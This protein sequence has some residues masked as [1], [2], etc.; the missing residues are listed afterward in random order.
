MAS[1]SAAAVYLP[2]GESGSFN[3]PERESNFGKEFFYLNLETIDCFGRRLG[4]RNSVSVPLPVKKVGGVIFARSRSYSMVALKIIGELNDLV[5]EYERLQIVK[6]LPHCINFRRLV[7]ADREVVKRSLAIETEDA[8]S[9]LL[10][11]INV[12]SLSINQIR[13]IAKQCVEALK[14]LHDKGVVHGDIKPENI[15]A[16]YPSHI[17]FIDF[18]QLAEIGKYSKGKGTVR[19]S[20]VEYLLGMPV[21]YKSDLW[22]LGV[23]LFFTYTSSNIAGFSY[24]ISLYLNE[25]RQGLDYVQNLKDYELIVSAID[26]YRDELEKIGFKGFED[27]II[28]IFVCLQEFQRAFGEIPQE[29][30][31]SIRNP[32]NIEGDQFADTRRRLSLFLF[33]DAEEDDVYK[34]RDLVFPL[35]E[36]LP[37]EDRIREVG[38]KQNA[39]NCESL[40]KFIKRLCSYNTQ[41]AEELLADPFLSNDF[42]FELSFNYKFIE[43]YFKQ[44]FTLLVRDT[45]NFSNFLKVDLNRNVRSIERD[46]FHL[47]KGSKFTVNVLNSA[48]E[49]ISVEEIVEITEGQILEI[50]RN[51]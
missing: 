17:K 5:D 50:G 51:N 41:T 49:Q 13:L 32:P 47:I 26:E 16:R 11:I 33:N 21:S 37:W 43:K 9:D 46:C 31:E 34:L 48:E 1:P 22:S 20:P 23:T 4:P 14:H 10:E 30:I 7:K 24:F 12:G 2:R 29:I 25:N 44:N 18:G 28:V 36:S 45:E 40:I 3:S 38:K 15:A 8:G 42:H 6:G 35:P 39:K 19:Y 27:E